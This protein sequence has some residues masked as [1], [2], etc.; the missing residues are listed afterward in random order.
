M[1]LKN[2]GKKT[3]KIYKKIM[4]ID[5]MANQNHE[6]DLLLN[7]NLVTNPEKIYKK[8][9]PSKCNILLGP[10]YALLQSEYA[11]LHSRAPSRIGQ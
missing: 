10:E 5:D 8:I 4:V 6:C 2:F 3:S 11:F 9:A 7:Q 1:A